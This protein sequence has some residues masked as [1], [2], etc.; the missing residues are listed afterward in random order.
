M[1]SLIFCN[2]LST[3]KSYDNGLPYIE[4]NKNVIIRCN[5]WESLS[6]FRVSRNISLL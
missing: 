5:S 1:I 4:Q 3:G 2:I 6:N